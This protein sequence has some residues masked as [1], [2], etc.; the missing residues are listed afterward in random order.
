MYFLLYKNVIN[1]YKR[2]KCRKRYIKFVFR[3]KIHIHLCDNTNSFN[4]PT[5]Y[6]NLFYRIIKFLKQ[7]YHKCFLCLNLKS[8]QVEVI[9]IFII[10]YKKICYNL[11]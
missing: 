4:I 7:L 3:E 9:K 6:K 2:D 1:L 10:L 11:I 8:L 5:L